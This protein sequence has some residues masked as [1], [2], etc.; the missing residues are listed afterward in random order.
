MSHLA[1]LGI[2]FTLVFTYTGFLLLA[3]AVGWHVSLV[4]T[5]RGPSPPRTAPPLSLWAAP[6]QREKSA[7]RGP[8]LRSPEAHRRP[9]APRCTSP[10]LMV[11][12]RCAAF[13][14]PYPLASPRRNANIAQKLRGMRAKWQ[15]LRG[16]V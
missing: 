12:G 6:A 1:P 13:C 9:T 3:L 15:A 4:R 8:L 10:R 16:R 5:R 7:G 14:P 2:L 11:A